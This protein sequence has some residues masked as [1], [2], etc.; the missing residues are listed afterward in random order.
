MNSHMVSFEESL[1]KL[2]VHLE[3][4]GLGGERKYVMSIT[5]VGIKPQENS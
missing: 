3:G 5:R 2:L 4:G 1:L